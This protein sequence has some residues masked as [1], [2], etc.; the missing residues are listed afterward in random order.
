MGQCTDGDNINAGGGD[1]KY[2]PEL[3]PAG[4]L[5]HGPMINYLHGLLHR[6]QIH[7]IEHDDIDPRGQTLLHLL[8]GISHATL[9]TSLA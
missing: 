8:Q 6:L 4:G 3:D 7:I 2:R 1:I 9:E 5:N